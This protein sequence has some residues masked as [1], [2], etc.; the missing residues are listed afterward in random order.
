MTIVDAAMI[1]GGATAAGM[2]HVVVMDD[3]PAQLAL[4]RYS[5]QLWQNLAAE[6]PADCEYDPVRHAVGGCRRRR[7]G[8]GREKEKHFAPAAL[9][10]NCSTP[11]NSPRPSRNS[12][13]GWQAAWS[14]RAIWSS[15]R[16]VSPVG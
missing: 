13:P 16:P 10:P 15:I 6:L 14:C 9:P 1:G 5:Q 12:A 11:G 2:G 3:S 4:T 8:G 7:V